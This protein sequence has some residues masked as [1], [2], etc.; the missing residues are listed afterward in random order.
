MNVEAL[1]ALYVAFGGKL[2]DTYDDI[3]GG[4]AVKNYVLISDVIYALAEIAETVMAKVLPTVSG[5][6]NGKVLTVVE[7]AWAAADAPKELPTVDQS[8]NGDVLTVADGVWAAVTP[9]P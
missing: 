5:A 8:N 3:A 1:K 7:G 2:T 6:N 4:V 9:T